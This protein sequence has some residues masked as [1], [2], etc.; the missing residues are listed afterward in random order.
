MIRFVNAA[1]YAFD[2]SI[3]SC[4]IAYFS[5]VRIFTSAVAVLVSS[6]LS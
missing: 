4:V 1:L 2:L 5:F 3:S 6:L